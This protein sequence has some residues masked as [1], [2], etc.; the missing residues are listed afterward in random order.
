MATIETIRP[1]VE[2][3]FED[4]DVHEHLSRSA[5]NLRA[6]RRRAGGAKSK[7]R[8]VRDQ[9]LHRRLVASVREAVRAGS[10]LQ[11]ANEK[12]LR[13]ER[14]RKGRRLILLALAGAL[15][16]LAVDE[17]ARNRLLDAVGATDP[18]AASDR[19]PA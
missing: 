3:L 2:Q 16:Y 5:A 7:K 10:S 4:S 11:R 17:G 12:Q 15:A 14:R 13:R 8:A 19:S 18:R 1:Y 9:T 6:A